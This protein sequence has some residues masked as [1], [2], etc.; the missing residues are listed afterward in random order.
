[1]KPTFEEVLNQY[2]PMI[3]HIIKTLNIYKEKDRYV[4]EATIALWEAFCS[5]NCRK[6]SFTSYAYSSIRGKLLN[7]L[8]K[9]VR[10]EDTHMFMEAMPEEGIDFTGDSVDVGLEEY[11]RH[12]TDKQRK[13]VEECIIKGKKL[14]EVARQE[15][16][17]VSAVK[18]WRAE[19]LK[20]LRR[21]INKVT[22]NS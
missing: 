7:H 14:D 9:E 3:H 17:T 20:K 8:K 11:T 1:M 22:L 18:S 5:Q 16:V 13:W 10:W 2:T 6:G 21:E 15:E 12:L 19:A 4:H